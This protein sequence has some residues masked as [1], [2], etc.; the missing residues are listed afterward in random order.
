M[1]GWESPSR[2][3]WFHLT[4]YMAPQVSPIGKSNLF[5]D[6]NT[7]F[8]IFSGHKTASAIVSDFG[9]GGFHCNGGRMPLWRYDANNGGG[10]ERW[11][12]TS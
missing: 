12:R 5:S 6:K 10:G 2:A 3:F 9:R 8:S 4:H 1:K 11:K 7:G